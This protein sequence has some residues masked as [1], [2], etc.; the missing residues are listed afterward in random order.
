MNCGRPAAARNSCLRATH[1]ALELKNK[2]DAPMSLS[3]ITVNSDTSHEDRAQAIRD[4]LR[5]AIVD[6]RL[7]PEETGSLAVSPA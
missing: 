2:Q 3:Q 6:R 4:T 5:D 7:A 1:F